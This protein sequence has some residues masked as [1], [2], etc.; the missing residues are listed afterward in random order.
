VDVVTFALGS[1]L[2]ALVI[3]ALVLLERQIL[4]PLAQM[5]LAAVA[6]REGKV[7]RD[8][9]ARLVVTRNDEI[10]EL[11]KALAAMVIRLEDAN[12]ELEAFAYSISHDLRA[13]LRAIDGFIA[14]LRDDYGSKLDAEGLRLFGVVS[15]NARRMGELIDDIL[16]LSRA[17]RLELI[18][19]TVDMNALVDAVWES[20]AEQRGK[21]TITFSRA[22]LPPIRGD[23]RA[24]RQ[25]WQNL[26]DNAI[27]F[28][29]GREPAR[30][31][32]SAQAEKGLIWFIVKDN[33]AG[34]NADYVGKLFGLFSRLHGMD[35][36]EGTGVGLAIVK[37][38]VQKHGGQVAAAGSIDGGATFRFGLPVNPAVAAITQ[39]E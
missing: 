16:A 12:K 29:R 30:I 26:L 36:F 39:K 33:G 6:I 19:A 32:V 17:G 35:E 21:P 10:G 23:A 14:I 27:K 5:R 1:L 2:L 15:D 24:L 13:P 9:A 11:S 31:E 37:R 4:R 28:S 18:H 8:I 3:A 22:D 38:F 25:V 7:E 20:L 34:F